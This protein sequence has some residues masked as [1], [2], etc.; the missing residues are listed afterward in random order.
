MS[1]I[2]ITAY[3]V[4]AGEVE[5]RNID[6]DVSVPRS[7]GED[8][9]LSELNLDSPGAG[10]KNS[11]GDG[12]STTKSSN[13]DAVDKRVTNPIAICLDRVSE[14]LGGHLHGYFGGT[15]EQMVD[16][17]KRGID[18][19]L[20]AVIAWALIKFSAA[21]GTV[22][23]LGESA[24][25]FSLLLEATNNLPWKSQVLVGVVGVPMVFGIWVMTRVAFNKMQQCTLAKESTDDTRST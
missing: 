9:S 18:V 12:I 25:Q 21:V 24:R 1:N 14:Y 5:S 3:G 20:V 23:V 13:T 22:P 4:S 8:L 2:I 19:C 10:P 15:K 17:S 6:L 16:F 7:S 11:V